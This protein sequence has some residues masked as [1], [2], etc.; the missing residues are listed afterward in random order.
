MGFL[1]FLK[2]ERKKESFDEL[3]LPPA[4][5]LLGDSETELGYGF[6]DKLPELPEFPDFGKKISAPTDMPK[7]DFPEEKFLDINK[8]EIP[9]FNFPE[10][11]EEKPAS[12]VSTQF[13]NI[14]VP[15]TTQP[16]SSIT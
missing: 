5:P 9:D 8:E 2:R 1:K 3:D 7:F 11:E 13:P 12:S 14:K 6:E 10:I 4:P 15:A 16:D